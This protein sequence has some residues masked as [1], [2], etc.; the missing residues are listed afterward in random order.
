MLV[1]LDLDKKKVDVLDYV[2][3]GVLSMKHEDK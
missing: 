2:M 1:T 3:K